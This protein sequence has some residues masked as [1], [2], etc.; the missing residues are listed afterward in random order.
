MTQEKSSPY[1]ILYVDDE[2]RALHYF[3][4]CFE[5]DYV[6][7]TAINAAE[8]FRILEEFGPRIG[9]LMTDQRMPG[10]KGV[11][12]MERAR[13]LQPNV[14]RILVTA[15]TDYDSAVKSVN[16]G[17]AWRYLHKPL[18]PELLGQVLREAMEA[19]QTALN[20]ERLLH[21]K[22]DDLRAQLMAD[23][24][25]GMGILAEGLNHHLRNALTVIRAFIDLA[26]MKLM[27]ETDARPPMDP[28]FWVDTQG[29]AL[30]Q[31]D[32]IQTLLTNLANASHARKLQ[33]QDGIRLAEVLQETQAAFAGHLLEKQLNLQ[34][35][36][37]ADFPVLLVHGER[38]IQMLRLLFIEEITHLHAGDVIQISAA[39]ECDALGELY[40]VIT[41]RDNGAWGGPKDIGA[42][43]FDPFYTRS[44]KP[45][46]FGVNMMACFVTMHLHGGTV[47][48]NRLEPAGLELVLRLPVDPEKNC[49]EAETFLRGTLAGDAKWSGPL[50]R[51]A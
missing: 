24:V 47:F 31:L 25:S 34:I 41:L 14:V 12:L 18:D 33:R 3:R 36:V 4:K 49:Q 35:H 42:N 45:D 32:R 7:H 6:I 23:R 13:R 39:I 9:V 48:A 2:E 8:G 50:S 17:R 46:D 16:D 27:E 20:Q 44:R 5:R 30:S 43:L 26:P 38:F 11:E 37:P 21:E 1:H 29:Q 15:Y 22:A 51:A 40:A 28:G 10:E 19:Y